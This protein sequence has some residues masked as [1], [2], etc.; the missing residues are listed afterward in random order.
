MFY[1]LAEVPLTYC[2]GEDK[3][4]IRVCT[5]VFSFL[6]G[7]RWSYFLVLVEFLRKRMGMSLKESYKEP[8]LLKK[9]QARENRMC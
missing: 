7:R 6:G 1:L 5:S 3:I 2:M 9:L 4:W 8:F